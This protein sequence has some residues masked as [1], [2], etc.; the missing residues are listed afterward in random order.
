MPK[1]LMTTAAISL[2]ACATL[3]SFPAGADDIDIFTGAS[4]GTAINPNILIVL[5][6][7]SN[8][9]RQA[10][11]W[12]SGDT[13]GQSEVRAIKQAI[14]ALD[15]TVNVGLF[16]FV[17]G[18]NANDN[19]GYVRSAIQ[20]MT[21]TA[22]A[23][24]GATLD[25]ID[26]NITSP[27]EKRN[28]GTM[29]GNLLFDVYNYLGGFN[30]YSPS[31]TGGSYGPDAAGY[32]SRYTTFQSPL[33]ADK[34]CAKT[35]VIFVTNP[36]QSGPSA[37]D[38]ANTSRLSGL[39]GDTSQLKLPTFTSQSVDVTT[40]LGQ[41]AVCYANPTDAQA[42]LSKSP[43]P[44]NCS[45][46]KFSKGCVIGS[47]LNNG[48]LFCAAGTASYA[49][50]GV[51]TET[52]N[53]AATSGAVTD[54][55]PYNAD[56]WARFMHNVG[57]PIPGTTPTL[58]SKVVFYTIDVYNKQEN[59][60]HTSL[61]LS[62]AQAGGG[63]YF[64]AKSQQGILDALNQ[65]IGE[66]LA[67]NSSFASASLPVNATNRTQNENQVYIGV[68][69]PDPDAKPRWFGN[70][71]RYQV[72][73]SGAEVK[74]GDANG[75]AAINPIDGFI[76]DC[77]QS[78]W[79]SDN[80]AYW[81]NLG[82]NPDPAGNCAGKNAYS[83]A[84]DGPFVEKG[85]VAQ[86]LRNGNNPA[87]TSV[88]PT[89]AVNRKLLTRTATGTSFVDFNTTNTGLSSDVVDY[90]SGK[91][92]N[93]ERNIGAQTQTR[94]SIH[95]DVIHSRPLP[96]N[97]GGT[98][99]VYIFYGANDG[100]FRAV[101]GDTGKEH[102]AFVAP[103][104]FSRLSRL[105]DQTPLVNYPNLSGPSDVSAVGAPKDYFF[106]GSAGSYQNADNTAIW[107]YPSMR[108]GGRM[109]Y[110]INA[111]DVDN[112]SLLW[113]AGCPNL[114]N[115]TGCTTGMSGIGQTWSTPTVAFIKGYSTTDPVVMFGGGYDTCEDANTGAPTCTTS[116]GG[117]VYILNG[118]TGALLGSFKTKR[119]VVGDVS[120]VDA[121]GDG[122]MDY[123]YAA[124]LGGNIYRIDFID[125]PTTLNP[126]A[127]S[128][129]QIYRVAYTNDATSPRKFM[130]GPAVLY[131]KGYVYLALGSGD[132]EHPL[133]WQYPY[134]ST[135][136]RFYVALDNLTVKPAADAG[137]NL[138]SSLTNSSDP[139]D[140]N[141]PKT[142]PNG[143][144][145]GWYMQL[146]AGEQV[147]TSALIAAGTVDFS[148]NRPIVGQAQSCSTSLGEAR[149]YRVSLL[150]ASGTLGVDGI[151]GGNRSSVFTGGGL[152]PNPVLSPSVP[153]T[154]PDGTI[155]PTT[156]CFGCAGGS[157]GAT[158]AP[159]GGGGG[160]GGGPNPD[161]K[162]KSSSAHEGCK[163]TPNIKSTRKRKYT[164]V[165]G[166]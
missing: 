43:W 94:P 104:F 92:V 125:G 117:Y 26:A 157:V 79:T 141:S 148:T 156:I 83:D 39:G 116:K 34:N 155:R 29:Y 75:N 72:I 159:S 36:D 78:Y 146:A 9:S 128:D 24:L 32:A 127:A 101:E 67:V 137:L 13:Q 11:K 113:A 46:D 40:N 45:T 38:S 5:D 76:T 70:L 96:V 122:M 112:P 105:K 60:D 131:N 85:G 135:S 21:S 89:Y 124:D 31:A 20:P 121:D 22:K 161:D 108:R 16:E 73:A 136:N 95:G 86:V 111:T 42:E 163:M 99:G 91:D 2:G 165:K 140:C 151:C 54:T 30:S 55:H 19:G 18:G 63:K 143:S 17:T 162:C 48:A 142:L 106:D 51:N 133:S 123:A 61:M 25:R 82:I 144:S 139:T 126:L 50:N 37:D 100:Y 134:A 8:W 33:N 158:G 84:P 90:I 166:Q 114:T 59:T 119:G 3:L 145:R 62:M 93:N 27:T 56:E 66:V 120:L 7:T 15:G 28:S 107:I 71:K 10:Q 44:T 65:I 35:I 53:V 68:F 164:Y 110:G 1:K 109:V 69:R 12:P 132:R 81:K 147:V 77:A 102:W 103:E 118:R 52:T 152:P 64:A 150:N 154:L 153:V 88:T 115:D 80:G 4:A 74:L 6:N 87:T 23:A 57:V 14:A 49:I 97:Y 98:K 47:A 149:G 138:D 160:S 41:T 130:F 129:W 58:K